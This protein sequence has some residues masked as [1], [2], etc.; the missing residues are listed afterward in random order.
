MGLRAQAGA[1]LAEVTTATSERQD[2]II[3]K[4]KTLDRSAFDVEAE[5]ALGQLLAVEALRNQ[6]DYILL[7]GFLQR[8]DLLELVPE[9]DRSVRAVRRSINLAKVRAGNEERRDNL[10]KNLRRL[11]VNDE[12]VYEVVPLLVYTRD[13]EIFRFLWELVITESKTCTPPDAEMSGRIDCAYRIVEYLGTA[14]AGFPV[15]IDEDHNLIT[16]DYAAALAEIRRWYAAHVKDY[17]ILT[18]TY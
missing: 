10:L 2:E 12:F 9:E 14:V 18:N 7:A 16:P 5:R 13:R 8:A 3:R 4:L 15:K 17:E 1:L 11:D 6:E